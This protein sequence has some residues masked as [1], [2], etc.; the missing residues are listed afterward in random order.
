MSIGHQVQERQVVSGDAEFSLLAGERA[1]AWVHEHR[2][3]AQ[4][5]DVRARQRRARKGTGC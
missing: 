5:A 4:A 1:L 2:T 3:V